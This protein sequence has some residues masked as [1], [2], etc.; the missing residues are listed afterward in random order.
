MEASTAARR[1]G[2]VEQGVK[3]WL[4]Y[5]VYGRKLQPWTELDASSPL[6][7]KRAAEELLQDFVVW[8]V[9]ACPG[10][11][12]ISAKTA[13]KYAQQVM[14]WQKFGD[15]ILLRSV[16]YSSVADEEKPIYQSVRQNNF[17]PIIMAFNI[18]AFNIDTTAKDTTAYVIDIKSLFTTDVAMIGGVSSESKA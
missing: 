16:S 4:K 5:T 8:L 15:K 2:H 12:Q 17:E 18:A 9:T 7:A 10:G 11:K 6:A 3:W 14:R 1:R 13:Q